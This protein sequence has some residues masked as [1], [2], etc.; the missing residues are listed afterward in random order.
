[1][2]NFENNTLKNEGRRGFLEKIGKSLTAVT[3]GAFGTGLILNKTNKYAE[4][5]KNNKELSESLEGKD[6]DF[7]KVRI[8]AASLLAEMDKNGI[9]E[10]K[11]SGGYQNNTIEILRNFI[12]RHLESKVGSVYS[13]REKIIISGVYT[14]QDILNIVK[15]STIEANKT[16]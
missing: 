15:V 7:S 11:I 2:N 10:I 1:M 5:E 9:Q 8:I 12:T 6:Q 14:K 3:V 4:A 13:S 16:K